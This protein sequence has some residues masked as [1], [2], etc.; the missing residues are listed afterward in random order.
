M[1]RTLCLATLAAAGILAAVAANEARQ[2]RFRIRPL[3][4][5]ENLYVL[6]SDPAQQG[7]RSGGNTAVFVTASGVALV[8]TKIR[9]YGGD[10]L[11]AVRRITDLPV[12]TIINT[13]TH[14]DHSGANTEF[15]DTIDFVAHENTAAHMASADCDDGAGFEGGSIKNCEAFTGAGRRYLPKITFENRTSLFSGPD[16]IDLHYFGRGH[17]DGDTWVVFRAARAAHAGD[18]MARKGLPFIDADNTNG[19]ATE[20]GATLRRAIDTLG[21]DVDTII[22]GH[23]DDPLAWDDLVDYAGFYGDLLA[24]AQEG[25]A[26][27]RSVAETAAAYSVPDEYGDFQ[28]PASRVESIVRLVY[29]GR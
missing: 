7:M 20:F 17:T 14:W 25:A 8:D 15:P 23:A 27:G 22:P 13:H 5:A 12:T 29:E 2:E 10:I 18:M 19:S 28:A 24:H 3:R 4:I 1:R 9:G 26:T 21:D 16:Q 6:T 11:A